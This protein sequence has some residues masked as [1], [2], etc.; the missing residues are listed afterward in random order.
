MS[1]T[2]EQLAA[3]KAE[4][5]KGATDDQFTNFI[6]ICETRGLTPGNQVIFQLRNQRVFDPEVGASVVEKR[7][8]YLTSIDAFRLIA[9]RSGQYAG[10]APAQYVYLDESN[11]PTIISEIPLPDGI[12]TKKAAQPWAVRVS[13]YRKGFTQPIT[14][15]ARFDAYAV[16][17]S[18]G[19]GAYKLN[20]MWEKRGAEQAAKCAEALA[21]RQAFPEELGGLHTTD[22]FRD[23]EDQPPPASPAIEPPKAPVIPSVAQEPAIGAARPRPGE[24]Q[25][26]TGNPGKDSGSP[27]IPAP[28]NAP[29]TIPVE[30]IKAQVQAQD[31]RPENEREG[32][33][34][35]DQ[36][37]TTE[38]RK[39]LNAA[40]KTF[41][42]KLKDAGV[43][44]AAAKLKNFAI[45]LTGIQDPANMS[46]AQWKM[47]L[48]ALNTADFENKLR[49]RV[50]GVV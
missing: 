43:K 41:N 33:S 21:L 7:A 42:K 15:T 25:T 31:S 36:V 26:F 48:D 44:D 13:V 12:S 28:Y 6:R 39:P 34:T 8:T 18:A 2:A 10:Q 11:K 29:D 40:L 37:P 16:Y 22:E 17:V 46:N 27:G 24:I 38:E 3:I 47:F 4:Y 23:E 14:A 1:Y 35:D 9:Q 32:T 20:S 45:G 30:E 50:E 49:E 5:C 19:Q